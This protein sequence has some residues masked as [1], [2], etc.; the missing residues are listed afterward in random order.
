MAVSVKEFLK[1]RDVDGKE[2]EGYAL[3]GELIAIQTEEGIKYGLP[4]ERIRI[5]TTI[6]CDNSSCI[7]SVVGDNFV[8][9]PMTISFTEDGS[10]DPA[11]IKTLAEVVITQDYKGEKKAFCTQACAAAYLKHKSREEKVIE[12]PSGKGKRTFDQVPE[13]GK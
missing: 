11:F 13:S 9:K 6:E 4:V 7:N 1:V 8:T 3:I 10:Q 2:Q 5:E 12:F